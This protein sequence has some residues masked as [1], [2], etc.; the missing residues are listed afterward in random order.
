MILG[1]LTR[2]GTW[3]ISGVQRD[4]GVSMKNCIDKLTFG[5]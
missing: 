3:D 5:D 4:H 1:L 2:R